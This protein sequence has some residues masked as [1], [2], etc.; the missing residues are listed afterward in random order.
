[1]LLINEYCFGNNFNFWMDLNVDKEKNYFTFS[2]NLYYNKIYE[3][4]E[5]LFDP[6]NSTI[7]TY[8]NVP[9]G[10]M[11]SKGFSS[12]LTYKLHP[13]LT[14]NAGLFHNEISSII[15]TSE[16]TKS[17]DFASSFK[18]KNVK[19]NFELSVFYKYTDKYSRYVG[20]IDMDTNEIYDVALNYLDSYHNMDATLSVPFN[21]ISCRMTI[22][23]KNIFDNESITSSGGGGVHSGGSSGSSLL[24][25][26][27][28][29]FVKLSYRFNKFND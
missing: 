5:L 24:N 28:T 8:F 7:A 20:S 1:L 10:A 14:I 21:R 26:G 15:N 2:N 4:I 27:R 11:I 9:A 25:W 3:K 17:T 19:Y 13:R 16:F 18:Y 6:D 12:D 29:Y 22:G 23:V